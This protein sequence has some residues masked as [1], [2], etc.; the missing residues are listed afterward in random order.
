VPKR[1]ARDKAD[2]KPFPSPIRAAIDFA[3]PPRCPG[4]SVIVGEDQVF[5]ADCWRQ[6]DFLGGPGC[7]ACGTPFAFD[8]GSDALCGACLAEPPAHDGV[9]AAVA[10]GDVARA[11]VLKLKHGRRIAMAEVIARHMARAAAGEAEALIVP[12]PLHRWR[13]W[14]RGFNQSLLIARAIAAATGQEVAADL[15]VRRRATPMLRGLGRAGRA[16]AL[17]G[18]FA[19][20]SDR[21]PGVRGRTVLLVD[22]VYTSGATAG[23]C[24]RAL[25]R[26]GAARVIVLTWARVLDETD[27]L[28]DGLA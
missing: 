8:R 1:G 17:R 2:V 19:V 20:P 4:C 28:G 5:C 22:D 26:G 11:V 10:Y 21:R 7:A 12:V 6:L 15:L 18:A 24:A 9:R 14:R 3:L 27:A 25:K 13:L 16:E 23:A